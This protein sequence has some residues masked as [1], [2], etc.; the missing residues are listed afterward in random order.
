MVQSYI[1]SS[2]GNMENLYVGI[3]LGTTRLLN[4]KYFVLLLLRLSSSVLGSSMD[5]GHHVH[6]VSY[7]QHVLLMSGAAHR[8][9]KSYTNI[10]E[11]IVMSLKT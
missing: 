6:M 1:E 9:V 7:P 3:L 2:G 4:A 8:Q 11:Q 5:D 10:F